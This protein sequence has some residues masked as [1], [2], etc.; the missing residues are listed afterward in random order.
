MIKKYKNFIK[1][2]SYYTD[3]E[4]IDSN[5]EEEEEELSENEEQLNKLANMLGMEV[6]G[7]V[8]HYKNMDIIYPSET[9][10]FHIG[11]RKFDT[12][13]QALEFI[14]RKS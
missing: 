3:N 1:E 12:A 10:K 6:D 2:E 5:Y 13:E 8:I 4:Y 7:T 9:N 14:Q 11:K